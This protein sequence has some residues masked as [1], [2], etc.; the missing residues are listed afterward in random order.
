[1]FGL[2][3]AKAEFIRIVFSYLAG[4]AELEIRDDQINDS[5]RDTYVLPS[6]SLPVALGVFAVRAA[7]VPGF[8]LFSALFLQWKKVNAE[9]DST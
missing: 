6:F 4:S 7:A 3:K 2:N 9:K 1:M 5:R 8:S